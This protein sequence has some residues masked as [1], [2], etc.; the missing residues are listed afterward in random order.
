MRWLVWW[1]RS[2]FCKHEWEKEEIGIK[3]VNPVH[4]RNQYLYIWGKNPYPMHLHNTKVIS[5]CKKCD[6]VRSYVKASV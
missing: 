2:I 6:W 4:E 5:T 1:F 3:H